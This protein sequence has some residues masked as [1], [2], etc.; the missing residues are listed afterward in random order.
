MIS[1]YLKTNK[2]KDNYYIC[3]LNQFTEM[4]FRILRMVNYPT[5]YFAALH[6][7]SISFNRYTRWNLEKQLQNETYGLDMLNLLLYL[8]VAYTPKQYL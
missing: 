3:F 7:L 1:M 8:Q 5:C 4:V 2:Y 6:I